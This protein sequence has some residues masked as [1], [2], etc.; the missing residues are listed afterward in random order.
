MQ[1]DAQEVKP[2][3][4]SSDEIRSLE[5]QVLVLQDSLTAMLLQSAKGFAA[6]VGRSEEE[7]AKWW[8]VSWTSQF[9]KQF[10]AKLHKISGMEEVVNADNEAGR[11][12]KAAMEWHKFVTR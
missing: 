10:G 1:V 6:L 7:W 3:V 2:E 9:G 11:L 8:A 5:K 4:T 12:F